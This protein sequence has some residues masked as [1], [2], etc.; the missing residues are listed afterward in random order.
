MTPSGNLQYLPGAAFGSLQSAL[1]DFG[2]PRLDFQPCLC[3]SGETHKLH[4]TTEI[5]IDQEST[6]QGLKNQLEEFYQLFQT[7]VTGLCFFGWVPPNT[8]PTTLS[9][10]T[11]FSVNHSSSLSAHQGSSRF[12]IPLP[13]SMEKFVFWMEDGLRSGNGGKRSSIYWHHWPRNVVGAIS[14]FLH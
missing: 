2:F 3:G 5:A 11:S 6:I 12:Q 10:R 9:E 8:C 1:A 13:V 4:L 7:I 14:I